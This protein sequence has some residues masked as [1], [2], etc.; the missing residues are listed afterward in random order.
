MRVEEYVG[1]GGVAAN[2]AMSI[3]DTQYAPPSKVFSIYREAICKVYMPWSPELES[4]REF[5]ARIEALPVGEGWITRLRC[6]PHTTLR[7]ALD[8]ANSA[9]ECFF[10]AYFLS[11]EHE[12]EKGGRTNLAKPGDILVYDSIEPLRV[13]MNAVPQDLVVLTVPKASLDIARDPSAHLRNSLLNQNRTPLASCLSLIGQRLASASTTELVSLYEA[14]LSLLPLE[15]GI[16]DIGAR[17][18]LAGPK[19]HYL[20]QQ[21]LAY[22]DG[23]I[24]NADL[25]P[26]GIA[27]EF[28]ISVRYVHKLFIACGATFC[29]YVTT[30]R[31]DY[32][33]RDLVSPTSRHVPIS[34][35]AYRWGFNDLSSFNRSFKNRFGCTP[36]RYRLHGGR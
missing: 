35:V 22:I 19:A 20:L 12:L 34:F 14:C 28:G 27:Q 9:N 6:S 32:V 23:N 10:I 15:A 18:E 8:V 33:R 11:G 2:P 21:I 1:G 30:K 36:S 26:Q 24:P 7:T 29:S 25:S 3:W 4:G 17:S 31:L 5:Q 16:F 13:T